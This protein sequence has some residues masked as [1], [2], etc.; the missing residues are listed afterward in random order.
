M[1]NIARIPYSAA[2]GAEIDITSNTSVNE[3]AGGISGRLNVRQSPIRQF[4]LT[5]GPD[6]S[7]EVRAIHETHRRRW[8]VA[9]RDWGR[10]TFTN[11]VLAVSLITTDFTFAP[12]RRKIMPATGTRYLHQRILVPDEV[13]QALTVYLD[14]NPLASGSWD[15]IDFGIVR[16]PNSHFTSAG[17]VITASGQDLVPACF[18]Q[19][20]LTEKMQSASVPS[21]P[22]VQLREI[23]EPELIDL[24][25]QADDSE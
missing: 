9:I 12:L 8:P 2:V 11:E 22:D 23:L 13:Q 16:I 4:H 24:M 7:L 25:S 18:M 19:D 6:T 3:S 10:Y 14:G 20:T 5:I 15:V 1:A 17:N 21:L